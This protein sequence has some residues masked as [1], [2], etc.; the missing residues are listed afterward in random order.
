MRIL[1]L[2]IGKRKGSRVEIEFDDGPSLSLDAELVLRFHLK[3]GTEL[4]PAGRER[5]EREQAKLEARQRLVRHL[6]LRRKSEQEARDYLGRLGF[7]DEAVEQAVA[8]A[9]ELGMLDDA[10]YAEAYRRTQER[11]ARKGHRAIRHELLMRGVDKSVADA[12][13]E[14][15]S[16]PDAQRNLA[17]EA[18]RRRATSLAKEEPA[19]ARQKLFAFLMRKGFDGDVAG[20]VTRELLGDVENG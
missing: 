9:R 11:S 5:I 3:R 20:Q 12:A 8:A 1:S 18:A 16:A 7:D 15:S 14:P 2:K 4:D 19:K 17:R 10:L 6:A 13:L